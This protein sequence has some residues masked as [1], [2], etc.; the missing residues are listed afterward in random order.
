M[1]SQRPA[2]PSDTDVSSS[3]VRAVP[4]P[5]LLVALVAGS[6]L[7][8]LG[9]LLDGVPVL[10]LAV[11]AGSVVGALVERRDADLASH[12]GT[13]WSI[14]AKRVMR[15]G[16]VL[17]GLRLALGDLAE[18]GGTALLVVAVTVAATFF[19]TQWIGRRL[20][21][22]RDTGLLVATGYSICGV[23]AIAAMS[24]N[25]RARADQVATAV[26]LVTLFG[27]ASMFVLPAL[28]TGIG[29]DDGTAGAWIGAATHD[30]A[31]VVAAAASLDDDA[32]GAAVVVKL[33]RVVLLA[34][35]VAGVAW[36][37]RRD[38]TATHE[39][40]PAAR[41]AP[42]PLFVVGFLAMILVR[43]SGLLPTSV[44]DAAR[45]LEGLAFTTAMFGIGTTVRWSTLRAPGPAP[46][47]LGT[48]AW[49][50]VA[51]VAL[52]GVLVV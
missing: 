25:T 43:T 11:V 23:S 6:G 13:G 36:W 29:L 48:A 9:R 22:E 21:V 52:T 47:L 2:R 34:P 12:L 46:L 39:G 51:G 20:G 35:L 28:A 40:H 41:P 26:A 16:V 1:L 17:L 19:G 24:P 32:V 18:L 15:I 49:I 8:L 44:T 14:A 33:A 38:R 45:V 4:A 42:V 3:P 30:V 31:Q 5:G 10:L 27:T 50:L 37:S 7:Y